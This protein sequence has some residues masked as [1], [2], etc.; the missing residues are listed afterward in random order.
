MKKIKLTKDQKIMLIGLRAVWQENWKICKAAE[1]AAAGVL[2][3]EH[4][5]DRAFDWIADADDPVERL[6]D[7]LQWDIDQKRKP[8]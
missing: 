5:E 1:V 3:K 2:G 6:E 7:L 8:K 4:D